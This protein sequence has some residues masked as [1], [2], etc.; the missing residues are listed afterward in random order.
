MARKVI[1]DVDPGIDDAVAM[2][3]ALLDPRLE[4]VAVTATGG[5]VSAEQASRNVHAIIEALDPPRWP[6]IGVAAVDTVLPADGRQLHGKN[7]L[8]DALFNVAE[9]VHRH[10]ADKVICEEVRAAPSD[11]TILALGP[12]TN[13]AAALQREHDLAT[14]VGHLIIRGGTVI[15][16]GDVTAAAEFNFYCNPVAARHVLRTPVTKTLLPLDVTSQVVMTYD[17]F[18]QLPGEESSLGNL[19]RRLLPFA[20][21]AY[22]QQWGMEGIFLHDVVPVVMALHPE[23]FESEAMFGGV[24]TGGELTTGMTVFDRRPNSAGQPNTEVVASLDVAG[25]IDCIMRALTACG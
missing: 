7:G 16:P 4:V 15:S 22:R 14:L 5:N 17:L 10:P 8:G 3:L 20:F 1:L 2:C 13:I 25:I 18:D 23:L 11:V 12:L 24:E 6:R 9:L 19:L 21:R